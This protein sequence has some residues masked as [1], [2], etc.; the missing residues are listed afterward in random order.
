MCGVCTAAERLQ[1]Q[2]A[3]AS[4][5]VSTADSEADLL[6][7]ETTERLT[8]LRSQAVTTEDGEVSEP[9]GE[10]VGDNSAGPVMQ[11]SLPSHPSR[12]SLA[13][14]FPPTWASGIS[15]LEADSVHKP[16]LVQGR[17]EFAERGTLAELDI[18]HWSQEVSADGDC[19]AVLSSLFQ[20]KA[21]GENFKTKYRHQ[22]NNPMSLTHVCDMVITT[23]PYCLRIPSR[24]RDKFINELTLL[25]L[26]TELDRAYG[27]RSTTASLSAGQVAPEADDDRQPTPGP[28]SPIRRRMHVKAAEYG[29]PFATTSWYS[30]GAH[31]LGKI[32]ANLGIRSLT[33]EAFGMKMPL[34]QFAGLFTKVS[35]HPVAR[36]SRS[37]HFVVVDVARSHPPPASD[38]IVLASMDA[39]LPDGQIK[40][41]SLEDSCVWYRSRKGTV[42]T[43]AGG[44]HSFERF[45]LLGVLGLLKFGGFKVVPDAVRQSLLF[46]VEC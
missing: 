3:V 10:E 24:F 5:P 36:A 18:D 37:K 16:F 31:D 8:T 20:N 12:R 38:V 15:G 11:A 43:C 7:M 19:L 9:D 44:S 45:P 40:T 1:A 46:A 33:V 35:S 29:H 30:I 6:E 26:D 21:G 41:T 14:L 22:V 34:V 23:T 42:R 32:L 39:L 4:V 17:P 25:P 2:A 13:E 27:G 28:Q